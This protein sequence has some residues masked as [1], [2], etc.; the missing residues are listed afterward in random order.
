VG[1]DRYRARYRDGTGKEHLKRFA[2]KR[3]AQRWLDQ[4][5]TKLQTGTWVAPKDAKTT[6]GQWCEE[7]LRNQAT[8]RPQTARMA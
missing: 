5:T 2:L 7:W 3:D 8:K 4:E 6:V 1:K